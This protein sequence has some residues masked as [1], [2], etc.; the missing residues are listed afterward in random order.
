MA[1][2]VDPRFGLERRH[3][4]GRPTGNRKTRTGREKTR[5]DHDKKMTKEE[6]SG[7]VKKGGEE[8][9]EKRERES[10]RVGGKYQAEEEC[11]C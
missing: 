3:S 4:T 5:D 6:V 10:E 2:R 1:D 9:E 7:V 11:Q 8:N